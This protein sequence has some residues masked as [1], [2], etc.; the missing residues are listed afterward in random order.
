MRD[1]TPMDLTSEERARVAA[2]HDPVEAL[3]KE[4]KR[5]LPVYEHHQDGGGMGHCL[6]FGSPD[7]TALARAA[8][9]R[10]RGLVPEMQKYRRVADPI[11][12]DGWNAC[13]AETLRRLGG[14][15]I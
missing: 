1:D 5:H 4:L 2:R 9:A 14:E 3:A 6:C 11:R 7:C 12:V 10:A 13:R 15:G 8:L